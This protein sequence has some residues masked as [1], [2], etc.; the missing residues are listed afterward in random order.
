MDVESI[1]LDYFKGYIVF[2]FFLWDVTSFSLG[3]D[4]GISY[5]HF[6]EESN[7]SSSTC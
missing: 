3:M 5:E 4:Q 6:V 1:G 7:G 2:C